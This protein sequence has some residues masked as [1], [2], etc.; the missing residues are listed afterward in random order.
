VVR[1]DQTQRSPPALTM[2]FIDRMTYSYRLALGACIGVIGFGLHPGGNT[3]KAALSIRN[4]HSIPHSFSLLRLVPTF[5][6][7]LQSSHT[8]TI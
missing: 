1:N 4:L 7:Q 8:S 2:T 3:H 5:M 6:H